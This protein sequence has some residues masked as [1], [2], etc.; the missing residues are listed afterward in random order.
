VAHSLGKYLRAGNEVTT[1]QLETLDESPAF[2]RQAMR[3]FFHQKAK[4]KD[5]PYDLSPFD[6]IVLGTP[7]WAREPP[8]AINT[9]LDAVSGVQGKKVVLLLT[10]GSGLGK[11]HCFARLEGI[12]RAKGARQVECFAIQQFQVNNEKYLNDAFARRF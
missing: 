11:E 9:Y 12:I 6:L 10:Y 1:I 3:A 5:V 4:I 8:P 7:L 2:F